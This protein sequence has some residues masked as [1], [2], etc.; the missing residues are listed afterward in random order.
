MHRSPETL[1][2]VKTGHKSETTGTVKKQ[3]EIEESTVCM[4][5]STNVNEVMSE[6]PRLVDQLYKD[7][8]G[9]FEKANKQNEEIEDEVKRSQPLVGAKLPISSL[10]EMYD[11]NESS[12]YHLK[13]K[14]LA[15]VYGSL[16]RIRGDGNCFYRAMLCAE[17]E[18]LFTEVCKGWR[19]RLMKLGF[20]EFTT[21][22]FCDWFDE[23]LDEIASGKRNEEATISSLNEDGPSN[24][25][26]TFFRLVTSGYLRDNSLLYEGFIEGGRNIEQ[27]CRDEI[28]PM[29]KDC[30]HL[31]IIALTN[32]IQVSIR[33]EYMDRSAAPDGGRH[34]DFIVEGRPPRLFFLYRPGHYDVLY[35]K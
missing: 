16:R 15:E 32:A 35:K 1:D 26:V 33:I 10:V 25:Y 5:M 30:D 13:A 21:T 8:E 28:E 17:L 6:E 29:W 3:S 7:D 19:D 4:P 23:L 9:L 27:F 18:S 14:E 12:E 22:D 34:Y 31:G 2:E 20:P 24:Y 11:A